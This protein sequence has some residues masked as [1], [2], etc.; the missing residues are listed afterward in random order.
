MGVDENIETVRRFYGAGAGAADDSERY[1]YADPGI[2]WHVP[3][4][5][6]VSGRHE[7]LVAVFETMPASMQPLD[8]WSIQLVDLFGNDDLVL[9]TV[10]VRGRDQGELDRLFDS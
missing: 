8:G 10:N 5:N 6:H 4:D 3:G 1:P 9:A 2:V 7:G